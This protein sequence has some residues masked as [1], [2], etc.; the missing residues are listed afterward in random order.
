MQGR[1]LLRQSRPDTSLEVDSALAAVCLW[2]WLHLSGLSSLLALGC[3]AMVLAVLTHGWQELQR[4]EHGLEN[5]GTPRGTSGLQTVAPSQNLGDRNTVACAEMELVPQFVAWSLAVFAVW[6]DSWLFNMGLE[7]QHW[8]KS[9]SMS[10]ALL[11][12]S[13]PQHYE[14]PVAPPSLGVARISSLPE[15]TRASPVPCARPSSLTQPWSPNPCC[16]GT[17]KPAG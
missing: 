15:A 6:M 3:L 11:N 7:E 16:M 8:G 2:T 1:W 17:V 12:P 14:S 5:G 9:E 13:V 10:W 4:N